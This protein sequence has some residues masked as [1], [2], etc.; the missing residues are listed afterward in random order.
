MVYRW[1]LDRLY[2]ILKE[3]T[4]PLRKGPEAVGSVAGGVQV[5]EIFDMTKEGEAEERFDR[6]VDCHFL[7]VGVDSTKA[8][9]YKA[10][11]LELLR[12]YPEPERLAGGPSYI[13]VGAVLG[14]QQAAFLL[15]ALGEAL[16]LWHVI[17]P[18]KLGMEGAIADRAAGGGMVMMSGLKV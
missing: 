8:E 4:T 9:S 14:D 15:F 13:E 3:T 12:E 18:A 10:E 5:V 11:L 17:T 7:T 1:S 2:E 16:D 6:M